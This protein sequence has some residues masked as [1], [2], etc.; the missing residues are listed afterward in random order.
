[1]R[2]TRPR[3]RRLRSA[4]TVRLSLVPMA[5]SSVSASMRRTH[6]VLIRPRVRRTIW[7]RKR[8]SA[9][10]RLRFGWVQMHPGRLDLDGGQTARLEAHA[11]PGCP[12]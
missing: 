4:E 12:G 8:F 11:V 5:H 10:Q 2:R 6:S 7:P 1:M 9:E 3:P